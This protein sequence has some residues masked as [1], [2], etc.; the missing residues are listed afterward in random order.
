[1]EYKETEET[2]EADWRERGR[3][4]WGGAVEQMKVTGEMGEEGG[5]IG[6]IKRLM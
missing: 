3:M 4:A 6:D 2:G 1:M 5:G